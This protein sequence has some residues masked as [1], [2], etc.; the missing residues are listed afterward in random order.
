MFYKHICNMFCK[1]DALVV[2]TQLFLKY[3]LYPMMLM[4]LD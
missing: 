2:L 3:S 4:Y 1:H